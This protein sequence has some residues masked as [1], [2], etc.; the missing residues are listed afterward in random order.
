MRAISWVDV[1]WDQ[2][3]DTILKTKHLHAERSGNLLRVVT[4]DEFMREM[5]EQAQER[6]QARSPAVSTEV[7]VLPHG[8]R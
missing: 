6:S 5:A 4:H 1:P 8:Q 3:L 7:I 2:A